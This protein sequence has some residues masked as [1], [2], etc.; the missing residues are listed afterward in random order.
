MDIQKEVAFYDLFSS[1]DI[2]VTLELPHVV[3]EILDIGK[4]VYR[5]SRPDVIFR[6]SNMRNGAIS[7]SYLLEELAA[8]LCETVI[9]RSKNGEKLHGELLIDLEVPGYD[10]QI[11]LCRL[12]DPVDI[13]QTQQSLFGT[14][15][16]ELKYLMFLIIT[17]QIKKISFAHYF[18]I[19]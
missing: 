3:S 17:H 16:V 2:E 13:V 4:S 8:I 19:I 11:F 12:S 15:F 1:Q 6:C 9:E 18:Y 5:I 7:T 14:Y 10:K